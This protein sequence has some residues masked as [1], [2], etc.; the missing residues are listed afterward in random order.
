MQANLL[1]VFSGKGSMTASGGVVRSHTESCL[2]VPG[3]GE[4]GEHVLVLTLHI[5]SC[6]QHHKQMCSRYR[7]LALCIHM[8]TAVSRAASQN[9]NPP[10]L[11]WKVGDAK[12]V[13]AARAKSLTL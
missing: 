10:K 11:I 4:A 6:V 5:A 7:L 12:T 9:S 13:S 8:D 2:S 3:T 1:S